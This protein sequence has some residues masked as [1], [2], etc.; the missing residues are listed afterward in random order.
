MSDV[1]VELVDGFVRISVGENV[2]VCMLKS[3]SDIY[4]GLSNLLPVAD[5][6]ADAD[7]DEAGEVPMATTTDVGEAI[8]VE[9]G[10]RQ[11]HPHDVGNLV[12]KIAHNDRR[13]P[14]RVAGRTLEEMTELCLS[15]GLTAGQIYTHVGD[16][17]HNQCLK[18]STLR[19][20]FPSQYIEVYDRKAV[21]KE[22]A[23]VRLT[24]LDLM[25]VCVLREDTIQKQMRSKF[26][27][28]RAQPIENFA[29]D[30]QTFY[31]KK[32]HIN[33]PVTTS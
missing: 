8:E 22:I 25:Y 32:P 1:K 30:G 21:A 27:K 9:R 15:V 19:T 3:A 17:I 20:V 28:L 10:P 7:P 31:L 33:T 12:D 26:N 18:A 13:S 4:E 16:A 2:L 5:A 23:D 6:D 29:T 11:M 14:T 24:L